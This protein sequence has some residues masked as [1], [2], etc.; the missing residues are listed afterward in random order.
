MEIGYLMG[1]ETQGMIIFKSN[2]APIKCTIEGEKVFITKKCDG[3]GS[4]E[5]KNYK[6][7]HCGNKI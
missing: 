1:N 5:V 2:R 3:C 6:C 4:N 7:A